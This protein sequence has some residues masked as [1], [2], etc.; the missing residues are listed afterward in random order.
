M[1][2]VTRTPVTV[3]GL[4]AMGTALATTLLAAGHPTTVWNR[5]PE[6]AD[7]LIAAGATRASS[8]TDAIAASPVVIAC[9]LDRRSVQDVLE[10]TTPVL[11]DRALVNLTTTTPDEARE[12]AAW[13]GAHGAD[14]LDGGI[15]AGP[16]MIGQPEAAVLYS[17]ARQVFDQHEAL[18]RTLADSEYLSSDAGVASLHDFALLAGMYLMFA[19]FFHGSA[20]VAAAGVSATEFAARA[21]PWLTAMASVLPYSADIIDEGT[22]R[23]ELQTLDFNG[24]VVDAIIRTSEELGISTEVLAPV[25]VLIDRQ[26]ADGHGP[27]ALE[28]IV[29]EI[30]LPGS[31]PRSAS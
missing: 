1:S 8:P 23:T 14:Y 24:P 25:R 16:E 6:K 20:M 30:R 5:T 13:A 11:A 15:M 18:L 3:L 4:G 17:G 21:V 12:L 19:G 28:R 31:R 2:A 22:Y 9:L 27:R 26:V 10:Q 29:E 7:G